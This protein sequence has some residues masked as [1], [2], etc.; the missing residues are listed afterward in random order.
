MTWTTTTTTMTMTTPS[1]GSRVVSPVYRVWLHMITKSPRTLRLSTNQE[2]PASRDILRE[3]STNQEPA[4]D[5]SRDVA[6]SLSLTLSVSLSDPSQTSE[7]AGRTSGGIAS[8]ATVGGPLSPSPANASGRLHGG[9]LKAKQQRMMVS[10]GE[11]SRASRRKSTSLGRLGGASAAIT[12]PTQII[13]EL[14][15]R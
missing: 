1:S 3:L 11:G 5:E 6:L 8:R 10:T 14:E 15:S 13:P 12:R 7:L 2:P 4:F 9:T